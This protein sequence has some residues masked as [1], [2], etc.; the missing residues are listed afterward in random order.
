MR[1]KLNFLGARPVPELRTFADPLVWDPPKKCSK[2]S[3]WPDH[4]ILDYH[5]FETHLKSACISISL[6]WWWLCESYPQK[7]TRWSS[8]SSCFDHYL[9]PSAVGQAPCKDSA[10]LSPSASILYL[11]AITITINITTTK[12]GDISTQKCHPG[13]DDPDQKTAVPGW[14]VAAMPRSGNAVAP[15]TNSLR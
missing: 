13:H 8:W 15:P 9:M 2:S 3:S 14:G 1:T 6:F 4:V 12:V 10:I 5:L 7:K 11:P